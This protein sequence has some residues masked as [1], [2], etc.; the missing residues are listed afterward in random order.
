[1][2]PTHFMGGTE[3][4]RVCKWVTSLLQEMDL[5]EMKITRKSL[6]EHA[7]ARSTHLRAAYYEGFSFCPAPSRW[8]RFNGV[9]PSGA[10]L[11]TPV[12]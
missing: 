2:T 12:R 3:A 4:K 6:Y 9:Y 5:E 8:W 7:T 10:S 11:I 1:M